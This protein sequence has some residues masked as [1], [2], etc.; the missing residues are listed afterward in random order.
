MISAI[1]RSSVH[2][3]S[4]SRE[5]ERRPGG[6]IDC[7]EREA[8]PAMPP[9][10]TQIRA[11]REGA[12]ARSSWRLAAAGRD[13]FPPGREHALQ[14][15]ALGLGGLDFEL[16]EAPAEGHERAVDLVDHAQAAL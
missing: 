6:S 4:A 7:A 5:W 13:G 14:E 2:V 16:Q 10:H 3:G 1:S 8:V 15:P 9:R 12:A 11:T